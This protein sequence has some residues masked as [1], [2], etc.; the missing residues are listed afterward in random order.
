MILTGST[1]QAPEKV[2]LH[3]SRSNALPPSQATP[4]DA[5]QV[6]L[7]DH[8]LETLTGS[9]AGLHTRQV[10]AKESPAV[11]TAALAHLQVKDSST[12]SPVIMPDGSP[13]P[14]LVTQSRSSALGARD[15]PAVSSRYPNR[16][17]ASLDLANLVSGQAQNDL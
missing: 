17:A 6:L 7:I 5:I 10:L 11:Q 1:L 2:A 16:A 9:L 4:V 3:G 14:A 8:L 12:E 15:W 13:A